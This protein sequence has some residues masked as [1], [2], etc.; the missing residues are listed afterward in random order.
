MLLDFTMIKLKKKQERERMG[1]ERE[2]GRSEKEIGR[3]ESM[4]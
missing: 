4:E 2:N 1:E 3:R